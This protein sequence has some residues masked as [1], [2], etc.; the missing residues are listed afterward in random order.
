[1][2]IGFPGTSG[3]SFIDYIIT[4]RVTS[5][6]ELAFQYSE[7]LAYMP[8][9]YLIGDHKQMFPQLCER[10]IVTNNTNCEKDVVDNLVVLNGID[11]SPI[12]ENTTIKEIKRFVNSTIGNLN[13][14]KCVEVILKVAELK[15]LTYIEVNIFFNKSTLFVFY[16]NMFLIQNMI[17]SGEIQTSI[18]GVIVQNGQL[19]SQT[20]HNVRTGEE[21]LQNIVVTSRQQYGLPGDAVVY[22]CFNQLSKIDPHTFDMWVNVRTYFHTCCQY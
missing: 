8:H 11:L 21:V 19:V 13:H 12:S 14:T 5:P 17:T 15:N 20:Q 10:I 7:K 2:W 22:C 4:D 6:V 16:F 3:A 9:T 18:N 1:M